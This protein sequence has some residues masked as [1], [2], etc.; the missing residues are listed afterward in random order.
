MIIV[1]LLLVT[2]T[3]GLTVPE[4]TCSKSN[5]LSTADYTIVI[6]PE[7]QVLAAAEIHI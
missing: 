4:L 2:F 1:A 3:A 5:T 6:I 7:V